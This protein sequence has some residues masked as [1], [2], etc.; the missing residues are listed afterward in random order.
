MGGREKEGDRRGAKLK[1]SR[2]DNKSESYHLRST[3]MMIKA[4]MARN[5]TY[6]KD[7]KKG[8]TTV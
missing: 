3:R 8:R 7:S 1:E 4:R 2:E 5:T 6:E